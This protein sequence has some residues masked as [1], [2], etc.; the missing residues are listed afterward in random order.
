MTNV[1]GV[2]SQ[3]DLENHGLRNL[4]MVYW[5]LPTSALVERIVSRREGILA[6]EGAIVVR[7]G[8]YTGR[9]PNDKFIVQNGEFT[10]DIW[11]GK[12]NRPIPSEK[13]ERLYL[14][15]TA[16][17]QGRDIFV[18]DT[19]A[20]AHPKYQLPIRVVTER[21]WHSLFA[22]NMFI[23]RQQDELPAHVPEIVVL[24]APGFRAIPEIDG[25]N[26]DIFVILNLEKRMVLIG[27][28]SYAGEIKKSVF[29]MLNY[30]LPKQ[31]VCL[32]T[33]LPMSG[34]MAT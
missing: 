25:T 1:M 23:R 11:W 5:T 15:M 32:C 24:H 29:T 18:Q 4:N 30:L 21:A 14:R 33:A 28:T 9:A 6:H 31:G 34:Q 20:V 22:R 7:T 2:P 3:Y 27:G 8:N 10:A 16:Y 19:A 13:F 12:V 17:F 26:S